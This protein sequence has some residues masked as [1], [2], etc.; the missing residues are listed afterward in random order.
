MQ[1]ACVAA[2]RAEADALKSL[3]A[4]RGE[5]QQAIGALQQ[6][7]AAYGQ[8]GASVGGVAEHASPSSDT[9]RSV[10]CLQDELRSARDA[11]AAAAADAV[12]QTERM[13]RES[14]TVR[15]PP[16]PRFVT[17]PRTPTLPLH[18]RLILISLP[19]PPPSPL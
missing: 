11:A 12:Q 6:Q 4:Q 13:R 7:I 19:P 5:A 17:P 1:S 16:N 10:R 2:R 14:G 8:R 15:T 3:E 18:N 9:Q